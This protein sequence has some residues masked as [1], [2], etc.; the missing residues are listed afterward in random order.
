MSRLLHPLTPQSVETFVRA[1]LD[2][3]RKKSPSGDD[4][5]LLVS[6]L[7]CLQERNKIYSEEPHMVAIVE[8]LAANRVL[9]QALRDFERIDWTAGAILRSY[10]FDGN[11]DD[12][13]AASL[14]YARAT[15]NRLRRESLPAFSEVV[16]QRE[17]RARRTFTNQLLTE[18]P[19][20]PYGMFFGRKQTATQVVNTLADSEAASI[21]ALIGMGGIGKTALAHYVVRQLLPLLE[22]DAIVWLTVQ[23][24]N[25]TLGDLP[26]DVTFESL[27]NVLTQRLFPALDSS[28]LNSQQRLQLVNQKL[29]DSPHLIIIDNLELESDVV[30]ILNQIQLLAGRSKFLITSRIQPAFAYVDSYRLQPLATDE[31]LQL[32]KQYAATA[33]GYGAADAPDEQ[34]KQLAQSAAG[35]PLALRLTADLAARRSPDVLI[36]GLT[37]TDEADY[38]KLLAHIYAQKWGQLNDAARILML[39]LPLLDQ[40]GAQETQLQ[41]ISGLDERHFWP[42][43]NQL[44]TFSLID[45]RRTAA[46]AIRYSSHQLTRAFVLD[47][48]QRP[49]SADQEFNPSVVFQSLIDNS[50][51]WWRGQIASSFQL[52]HFQ[53][54]Q[55]QLHRVVHFGLSQTATYVEAATL[56]LDLFLLINSSE[57]TSLWLPLHEVAL[58]KAHEDEPQLRFQLLRR[59]GW[60]YKLAKAYPLAQERL[61]EAEH[62]ANTILCDDIASAQSEYGLGWLACER[63][64]HR[65][66]K[67]RAER[68]LAIR[69]KHKLGPAF[70]LPVLHLLASVARQMGNAD[71]AIALT[72]EA[73]ACAE[74][75]GNWSAQVVHYNELVAAYGLLGDIAA[76]EGSYEQAMRLIEQAGREAMRVRVLIMMARVY[77]DYEQL[78]LA[79]GLL[80]SAENTTE[81]R[82]MNQIERALT[83]MEWGRLHSARQEFAN[84]RPYLESNVDQ[85]RR[86]DNKVRLGEALLYLSI[87]LRHLRQATD[88]QR[89]SQEA[90]NLLRANSESQRARQLL[91]DVDN[92]PLQ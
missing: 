70:E 54:H 66:A 9:E 44:L 14:N 12:K 63:H 16:Y 84:A 4:D 90:I 15:A 7:L 22:Y 77:N 37:P 74:A 10:Y 75:T 6:L 47:R 81:Q 87:T 24:G 80:V 92:L 43:L 28:S 32:F 86:L 60:L 39:T 20:A 88:A 46:G 73:I 27:T 2:A 42:G 35:H 68:A 38:D 91:G 82:P 17:R 53:Q 69:R 33:T 76:A 83:D 34:L 13:V 40:D 23:S 57:N 29:H 52:T 61:L 36:T 65:E 31:A 62:L 48:T 26:P 55:E 71:R 3:L 50:L 5:E 49:Q 51:Q 1:A 58:D 21:V 19:A 59:A 85:W 79:H 72:H 67:E 30:Y 45:I 8:R 56:M 78:E 25:S 89:L 64:Q 11:S 18:L 41:T